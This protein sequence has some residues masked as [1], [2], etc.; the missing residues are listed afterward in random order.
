M[1][2]APKKVALALAACAAIG[3]GA[4]G[5]A[6]AASH[7]KHA[8]KRHSAAS[9]A[10]RS[11]NETVL[12]GDAKKSAE[13][14]ALAA[15]PGGTVERSSKEDPKDGAGAAYEVHVTKS[16]GSDVEVLEDSAFK[17]LSTKADDH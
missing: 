13:D 11:H 8:T 6:D 9:T 3:V 7:K 10:P 12:T 15:V 2:E 5:L 14:A 16:D 4:A 1:Q 17:V